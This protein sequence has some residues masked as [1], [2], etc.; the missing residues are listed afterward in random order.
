MG[1]RSGVEADY[2]QALQQIAL[3]L[4]KTIRLSGVAIALRDD[5]GDCVKCVAASG[6]SAPPV[7]TV[8][9]PRRGLSAECLRSGD[10]K[11]ANDS[12]LDP[13]VNRDACRRNGI[14]STV[15]VPLVR[16]GSPIGILGVYSERPNYFSDRQVFLLVF[17]AS[18]ISHLPLQSPAAEEVL[19]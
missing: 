12:E 4:R 16:D 2:E 9:D 17:I 10:T 3:R 7:G 13:R 15:V 11:V 8:L 5:N 19:I 1:L 18:F 14:R 6:F